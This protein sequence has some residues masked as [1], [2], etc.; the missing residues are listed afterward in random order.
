MLEQKGLPEVLR[1]VRDDE[2]PTVAGPPFRHPEACHGPCYVL[3]PFA[4]ECGERVVVDV[5][6]PKN[7]PIRK[8]RQ[9]AAPVER[10]RMR[11]VVVWPA[12]KPLAWRLEKV[13][14]A[15][16]EP[17]W[18]ARARELRGAGWSIRRIMRELGVNNRRQMDE[19]L[20]G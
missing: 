3:D 9:V 6:P 17:A 20:Y 13:P 11:R 1:P 14:V 2:I 7:L 12:G 5:I 15:P 8:I 16:S 18:A 4:W 19:I 10:R